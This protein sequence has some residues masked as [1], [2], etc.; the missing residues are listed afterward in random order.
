[1]LNCDKS[2]IELMVQR[3]MARLD[4]AMR[5]AVKAKTWAVYAISD[6]AGDV[7]YVGS[8]GRATQRY[9]DHAARGH[10]KAM[11]AWLTL[12]S[13]VFEVLDQYETKREMLDAEQE[14]VMFLQPQFNAL[15]RQN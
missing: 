10:N 7:V 8:S 3:H 1:M 13:H 5:M 15:H 9:Q 12:N 11:R 4:A 6:N 2:L 14:Y